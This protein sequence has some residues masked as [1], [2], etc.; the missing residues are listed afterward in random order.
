MV[1]AFLRVRALGFV[2]MV[3][4]SLVAAA[5]WGSS[6]NAAGIGSQVFIGS[7]GTWDASV[8]LNGHNCGLHHL[9]ERLDPL[10]WG[11]RT[12]FEAYGAYRSPAR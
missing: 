5:L 3:L 9:F 2:A 1:L 6:A 10:F 4:G 7:S 12:G 11:T 8:G